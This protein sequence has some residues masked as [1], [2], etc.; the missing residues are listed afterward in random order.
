[1]ELIDDLL[2]H[3]ADSETC[4]KRCP[5]PNPFVTKLGKSLHFS[6]VDVS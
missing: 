4:L 2:L 5:K 3:K 1:M 6:N